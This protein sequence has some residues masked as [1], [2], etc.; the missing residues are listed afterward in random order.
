M[1]Y[2]LAAAWIFWATCLA[3]S[4]W[5]Y[6]RVFPAFVPIEVGT[7]STELRIG[8]LP[9]D[10]YDVALIVGLSADEAGT[11]NGPFRLAEELRR[12]LDAYPIDLELLVLDR[13]GKEVIRVDGGEDK[14]YVGTR[15]SFDETWTFDQSIVIFDA[16]EFQGSPLDK[17]RLQFS[18]Q[19][20]NPLIEGRK[21]HLLVAGER[22]DGYYPIFVMMYMGLS[23]LALL[24]VTIAAWAI[25]KVRTGTIRDSS[26]QSWSI[27]T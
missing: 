4:M 3:Y 10:A 11:L 2:I 19:T 26:G 25:G 13:R 6:N 15:H 17:Y 7:D 12:S 1:R 20:D 21:I 18:V 22:D 24:I 27:W 16:I 5:S 9:W 23:F 14:W 8:G